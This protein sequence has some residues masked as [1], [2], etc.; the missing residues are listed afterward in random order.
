LLG[1]TIEKQKHTKILQTHRH[2]DTQTNT[3][4]HR[5]TQTQAHRHTGTQTH[6]DTDTQTH[7]RTDTQTHRHTDTQVHRHTDTHTILC[8][9]VL[10]YCVS[11]YST[12]LYASIILWKYYTTLPGIVTHRHTDTQTIIHYSGVNSQQAS[13]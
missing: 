3:D 2:T 11:L 8:D 6:M 1:K 13:Y 12:L 10:G 7:R 9:A 4:T 5:H